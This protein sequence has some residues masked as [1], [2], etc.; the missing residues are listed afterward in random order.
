M[1]IGSY[2]EPP[3]LAP[4]GDGISQ[5]LPAISNRRRRSISR[6]KRSESHIFP[7]GL[8]T[9]TTTAPLSIVPFLDAYKELELE[10]SAQ[11]S[12][13]Q[14]RRK[15]G[16]CTKTA[17]FS[18]IHPIYAIT[19]AGHLILRVDTGSHQCHPRR[20]GSK[21]RSVVMEGRAAHTIE[22]N[23]RRSSGEIKNPMTG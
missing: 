2:Q 6:A 16:R 7:R 15:A 3:L 21:M 18:Q 10:K 19:R 17:L 9:T 8:V 1:Y 5:S 13:E 14:L 11:S 23:E 20:I 22:D 4:A 12:A